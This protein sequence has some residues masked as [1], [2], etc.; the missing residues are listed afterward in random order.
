ML[1]QWVQCVQWAVPEA[2]GRLATGNPDDA[3]FPRPVLPSRMREVGLAVGLALAGYGLSIVLGLVAHE[4]LAIGWASLALGM[5]LV[6]VSVARAGP[7]PQAAVEVAPPFRWAVAA[8]GTFVSVGTLVYN[9]LGASTFTTPELALVAYGALLVACLPWLERPVVARGRVTV[10]T[11]VAWSFPLVLAP[12]A[13]Y[14]AN[15]ILTSSAGSETAASSPLV[16]WLLVEPTAGLL[17]AMGHEVAVRDNSLF[18]QTARGSLTLSVGLVCA[19][20]YPAVLFAG[21]F[22]LYVWD[23]K[24]P[25]RRVAVQAA[26]GFGALWGLNLA[27]MAVLAQVGVDRGTAALQQVHDQIGWLL[28]AAFSAVYWWLVLRRARPDQAAPLPDAAP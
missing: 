4:S 22:A 8:V 17:Q 7:Q 10:M 11:L 25:W 6:G 19:G 1:F 15:G 16:Q 20:I 28:F 13:I 23:R 12:L 5:A 21:L 14:A 18:L 2:P 24:P 9:L 26:A 3:L 27:R